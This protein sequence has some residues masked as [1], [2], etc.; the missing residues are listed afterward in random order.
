MA[1]WEAIQTMQPPLPTCMNSGMAACGPERTPFTSTLKH[2]SKSDSVTFAINCR[3]SSASIT[4]PAAPSEPYLHV[5][6]QHC[7][8]VYRVCHPYLDFAVLT[9]LGQCFCSVTFAIRHYIASGTSSD[10]TLAPVS[11]KS[12][13]RTL[14]PAF[15]NTCAMPA[16]SPPH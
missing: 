5:L 6:C 1:S 12:A 4:R 8:P 3:V 14:G 16:P 13:E 7:R 15:A 2:L 9:N 10:T 11:F